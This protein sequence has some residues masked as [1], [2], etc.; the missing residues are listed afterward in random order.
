MASRVFGRTRK[1]TAGQ[2]VDRMT[3]TSAG[4][5]KRS[6]NI[7][8]RQH[9]L[10]GGLPDTD[11]RPHVSGRHRRAR[12]GGRDSRGK[13]PVSI[14]GGT[15]F[16]PRQS[17]DSGGAMLMRGRGHHCLRSGGP[18]IFFPNREF[19]HAAISREKATRRGSRLILDLRKPCSRGQ[20]AICRASSPDAT[21]S[22]CVVHL[23]RFSGNRASKVRGRCDAGSNPHRSVRGFFS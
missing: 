15:Q 11:S 6:G 4:Q 20:A 5:G 8:V 22:P 19:A 13:L 10:D 14:S 18:Q 9:L 12:G 23:G 21:A 1:H 16:G 7:F 17:A 2:T 3:A